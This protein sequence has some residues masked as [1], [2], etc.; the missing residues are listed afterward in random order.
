LVL[1]RRQQFLADPLQFLS[2][3]I[4]PDIR[5]QSLVFVRPPQPWS[6]VPPSELASIL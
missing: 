2:D 4:I 1:G 5:P 3:R 6:T